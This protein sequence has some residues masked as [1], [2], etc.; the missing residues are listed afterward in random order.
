MILL[1]V[2]GLFLQP[3]S[4]GHPK[5]TLEFVQAAVDTE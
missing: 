2:I 5:D 4:P 3:S 1:F